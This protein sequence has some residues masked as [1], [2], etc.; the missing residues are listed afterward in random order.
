MYLPVAEEGIL[1]GIAA[2]RNDRAEVVV[3][4]NS[5]ATIKCRKFML[6]LVILLDGVV[7]AA[8]GK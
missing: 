8:P 2:L 5:I 1:G 7:A 3:M 4:L 6:M